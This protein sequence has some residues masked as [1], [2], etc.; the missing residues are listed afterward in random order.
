MFYV[1]TLHVDLSV[2]Q[3]I[4]FKKFFFW[5]FQSNLMLQDAA[6]QDLEHAIVFGG[7]GTVV[8]GGAGREDLDLSREEGEEEEIPAP[9]GAW[10]TQL[11]SEFRCNKCFKSFNKMSL[12]KKHMKIHSGVK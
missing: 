4:L 10:F 11:D 5:T 3:L 8:K 1:C 7:G 2:F 9:Q 6:L 12:L